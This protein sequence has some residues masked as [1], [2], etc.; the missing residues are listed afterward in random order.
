MQL[1]GFKSVSSPVTI[2]IFFIKKSMVKPVTRKGSFFGE[3]MEFNQVD[4]I[5]KRLRFGQILLFV[6]LNVNTNQAVSIV[7]IG[8]FQLALVCTCL[9]ISHMTYSKFKCSYKI[10]TENHH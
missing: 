8:G 9:A 3:F 2:K 10:P 6:L 5:I 1:L 7:L 4:I